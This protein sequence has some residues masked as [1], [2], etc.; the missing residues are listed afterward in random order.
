[1]RRS[2]RVLALIALQQIVDEIVVAL[3]ICIQVIKHIKAHRAYEGRFRRRRYSLTT[4]MPDQVGKLYR[5]VSSSNE[6]C[7]RNHC[8]DRN[9]FGRLCYMLEQSGGVKPTKNV[10][11][12]E[13]VVMFR[14][15]LSHHKKNCFVKHDFI[16]SSHIVS[17]PFH[18]VLHVVCEMQT[19][20][21]AKPTPIVDDCSDPRWKWFKMYKSKI[22][23]ACCLLHNFIRNEMPEDPFEHDFPDSREVGI[24]TGV[25]CI[26]T[27]ES[28]A[29]WSA[30]RGE[31][32]AIDADFFSTAHVNT[33]E[34]DGSSQQKRRG[35]N[36]DRS[37]P[38]RTWTIVEK[39]TLINGL[40]SLVTTRWKCDNGFRNGY[41]AQL[42][43]HMKRVFPQ[44]HI[45]VE[46][47]INLKLH[48]RKNNTQLHAQ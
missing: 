44:C 28:N 25:D 2:R 35:N 15:V 42:E 21:L 46:P 38:R 8:M 45:K 48:V 41:L 4:R 11:V 43:A 32:G 17:K 14:S 9:A 13:Q 37:G 30:W 39:E 20:L 22:I 40:K 26:S 36:K 34:D 5:L 16:R 18:G 27:I 3:T 29:V 47:H 24:E 10:F 19:V 31:L 33:L 23:I 7:L 1:M 6:T 12:P